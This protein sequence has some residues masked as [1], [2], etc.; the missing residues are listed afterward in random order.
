MKEAWTKD[1][2]RYKGDT[3]QVPY[4]YEDGIKNWPPTHT[5]TLPYGT[6]GEVDEDGTVRAVSVVPKPLTQPHPKL[7]QA[8]GASERTLL[9]CGENDIAPTILWGSLDGVEN[10]A[11]KYQEGAASRGRE[12]PLGENIGLCRSFHFVD[13]KSELYEKVEKYEEPV[14]VGWYKQFGFM[15]GTRLPGEEGPV[16][17]PDEHL[18]DRLT[19]SGILVG[20]TVDDVKREVEQILN[21]IPVDY[22][23]WLFHWGLIPRDEGLRQLETFATEIMPEFGMEFTGPETVPSPK[24]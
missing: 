18:A 5:T 13:D 3:Y 7:F 19:K 2:L 14:W 9:W 15:E 12:V 1:L 24:S 8:F 16:P 21:R 10:L 22:F 4:P 11:R 23:V 6:P 20:G 17:R